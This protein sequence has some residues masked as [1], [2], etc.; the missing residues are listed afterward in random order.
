MRELQG[1][2][3][4]RRLTCENGGAEKREALSYLD[5]SQEND[6]LKFR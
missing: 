3:S 2:T 6:V 4:D 1:L 5:L